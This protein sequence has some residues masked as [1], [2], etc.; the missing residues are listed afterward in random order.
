MTDSGPGRVTDAWLPPA[1]PAPAA[2]GTVFS[3]S[4]SPLPPPAGSARSGDAPP[5]APRVRREGWTP[6][7]RR[8]L[9]PLRPIPFG[10]V[11]GA[12]FRLQRRSPRTTLAPALVVS[13]VTTVA[14]TIL[15]WAL[16]AG[17]RAAL[18]AAYYQDFVV[19]EALLGVIGGAAALVPVALAFGATA[20]LGGV[21]VVAASRGLLAERVSW[22][23]ALRRLRGRVPRLVGWSALVLL[24]AAGMLALG[25]LLPLAAALTPYSG[26]F[27]AGLIA[28]FEGTAALLLGGYLAARLSFATHAIA[29]EGLPV[30]AAVARSWR[31]TR[32]SGWRLWACHLAVWFAVLVASWVLAQPL[33][34][35]LDGGATLLFPNGW[36]AEQQEGYTAVRAV[37]VTV[38]AAV[39]GAFGLVL[40]TG[41]G[42]L[43]YL[44]Q[45]MRVEGL[46]LALARYVDE[47]QRGDAPADPF[48]PGDPAGRDGAP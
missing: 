46:D 29:L 26:G 24:V 6:P 44:D 16:T 43:L 1:S 14:A 47:R 25:T 15:G 19:A 48:P 27:V 34:W 37:V 7:P 22:R 4:G 13:L 21:V 38:A 23:G 41:T 39:M 3:A 35:A 36:T 9:V 20:L 30:G 28:F 18:D 5:V 40:Q 32:R 45:R 10:V 42:A 8:G 31:L 11:L 2:R 33:G 17:P 12:P